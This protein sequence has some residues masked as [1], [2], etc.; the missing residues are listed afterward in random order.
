MPCAIALLILGRI[1]WAAHDVQLGSGP[2]FV[3]SMG[4]AA[5][6]AVAIVAAL[7]R[8]AWAR[9]G[10]LVACLSVFAVLDG[11][12]A[13]LDGPDGRYDAVQLRNNSVAVPNGFNGSFERYQFLL[14]GN[15]FVPYDVGQRAASRS[16]G[17][18][19]PA[20]SPKD[21]LLA[22][23][24]THGA[25]AWEQSTPQDLQPPC[26]PDCRLLG[27]RW[28]FK[29]R[30]QSGEITLANLWY[31]DQWLFRREWLVARNGS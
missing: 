14:P 22:L 13:P 8:P 23:L 11:A 16:T 26:L 2:M 29:G 19:E 4:F 9:A 17:V 10:A 6:G 28:Y 15:R 20:V 1:A 18:A 3:L 5:V 27:T 30:H 7:A 24:Q 25:V 31:P 12:L 21:E